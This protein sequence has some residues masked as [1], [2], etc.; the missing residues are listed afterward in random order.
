[1]LFNSFEFLLFLPLALLGYYFSGKW[2]IYVLLVASYIFYMSWNPSYIF[3]ILAST[4]IDYFAAIK[5]YE[6]KKKWKRNF[7]LGISLA[8]NLG[9]LFFFKY[10]DFVTGNVVKAINAL[11]GDIDYPRFSV[12]LPVGISFYTFQTLSYT[13]DI[14]KNRINPEKHFATFALYVSFF[15][16]LVAG[17]IERSERLLPQ[18]KKKN[19]FSNGLL[20]SGS[21]LMLL[22]F[23][24]KIVIADRL[25]VYVN[26]VYGNISEYNGLNIGIATFFFAFQIYC[27]F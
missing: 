14:Y 27:D 6:S 12:L 20:V 19:K 10:Y 3:L 4:L 25:S 23:F 1:L 22:G 8:S 11:G 21:R 18:L 26:E 5:L 9:I 16:Q 24:K 2:R 13:I 17:P 15:P 7:Y